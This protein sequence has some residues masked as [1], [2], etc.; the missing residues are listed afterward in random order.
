MERVR[1]G[2]DV[3]PPRPRRGA[4]RAPEIARDPWARLVL[5]AAGTATPTRPAA[6]SAGRRCS[7][8]ATPC[9]ASLALGALAAR[10]RRRPERRPSPTSTARCPRSTAPPACV[11]DPELT[12]VL[13][14]AGADPDDGESLYHATEA[15]SPELPA[16]AARARRRRRSRSCSRTR[17][18]TSGW[19][20]CGCCSTRAPTR[21]SCSPHAVRRG[22]G[23]EYLRLLVEHGADLEYR[24]GETWRGDVPLRTAYQHAVLRGARRDSRG[25]AGRARR[26]HDVDADDLAV[27]AF[28][29]GERPRRSPTRSTRP[30][31][32]RDP[33]R[34]ARPAALRRSSSS[35]RT[36]AA[37][38]AARPRARCSSTRRGSATRSWC[39]RCSTR[40][41]TSGA[42]D[43]AV[44]GSHGRRAGRD[45]V[46]VAEQLVAAG[47]VIEPEH[48]G[49]GRRPAR[50]VAR[51]TTPTLSPNAA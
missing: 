17:S 46:G 18:T 32:G 20:T 7:T 36:S 31:G 34:A 8:S 13:L 6:R 45:Y 9:F 14:E 3:G 41:P 37:S 50:R 11:H 49:A 5:G 27:A 44:H 33:R 43:W 22:R 30:A 23:P 29:R 38:S 28:A 19:S 47:A 26:G 24:G 16:R 42:L 39:A 35:A 12:R 25:H 10:A 51:S 15:A 2:G 1:A 40:A 21:P 48:A 4:A